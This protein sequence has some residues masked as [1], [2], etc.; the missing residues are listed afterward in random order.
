MSVHNS[1]F[2]LHNH[3]F[4]PL[5]KLLQCIWDLSPESLRWGLGGRDE[6][7]Q[8]YWNGVSCVF[9]ASCRAL[10]MMGPK[11]MLLSPS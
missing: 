9:F 8:N 1:K 5:Q 2:T 6:L 3:F 7:N 10:T 4:S 11:T